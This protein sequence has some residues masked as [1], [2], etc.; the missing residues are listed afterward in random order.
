MYSYDKVLP[1]GSVVLLKNADKR[2]MIIGYRCTD[3]S[4]GAKV[5]DYC[6]CL[7]PEGYTSLKY[8]A[9][10]DHEQIDRIIFMGLQNPAQI[11]FAEKLKAL[12]NVSKA[13]Q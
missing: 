7:Y 6:G 1:I 5:Y 8:T 4:G 11:V 3:D 9:V 13:E 12:S 2:L 10:F